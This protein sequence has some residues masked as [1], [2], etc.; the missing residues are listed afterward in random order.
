MIEKVFLSLFRKTI[1]LNGGI[2]NLTLDPLE[3]IDVNISDL[4]IFDLEK[5][6]FK[7]LDQNVKDFLY[8]GEKYTKKCVGRRWGDNYPKGDWCSYN[9]FSPF[10]GLNLSFYDDL[11][12]QRIW[13][14]SENC[15]KIQND[16]SVLPHGKGYTGKLPFG[17]SFDL[18]RTEVQTIMGIPVS[19]KIKEHQIPHQRMQRSIE[20][21]YCFDEG[22]IKLGYEFEFERLDNLY[23]AQFLVPF[24]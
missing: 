10:L 9:H 3:E 7:Y 13:L 18:S 12:I 6:P 4:Q 15:L 17:L 24:S 8:L 1:L 2:R 22:C 16:K 5:E 20:D 14:C 11:K 21:T 23:I 19:S